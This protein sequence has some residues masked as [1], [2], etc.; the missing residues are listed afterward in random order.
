MAAATLELAGQVTEPA[1]G[2]W[3]EVEEDEVVAL[4]ALEYFAL[5][6]WDPLCLRQATAAE[7][8]RLPGMTASVVRQ[9]VRLVQRRPELSYAELADSLA[10]TPEQL[11]VLQQATTLDCPLPDEHRRVV[12]SAVTVPLVRVQGEEAFV[13][14]LWKL[15]G[16]AFGR[17]GVWRV[18]CV[19]DR[20]AGEPGIADFVSAS[21]QA[22]PWAGARC[23]VGDFRLGVGMG[24]MASSSRGFRRPG[25]ELGAPLRWSTEV[26]P[27]GSVQESSFLRGVALQWEWGTG[28]VVGWFSVAPRSGS[29]DTAGVVRS[30]VDD[31]I[32]ATSRDRSRRYAFRERCY[33]TAAE[34]AWGH[35]RVLLGGMALSYSHPLATQSRRDFAGRSG[36][37]TTAAFSFTP[38][39]GEVGVELVRDARGFWGIHGGCMVARPEFRLTVAVRSMPDGFRSPF[40]SILSR[41]T[42][43]SN[44][45]GLYVG[46]AWDEGRH[47]FW[48]YAD[49]FRTLA[50][51]YGMPI[52]QL[53]SEIG[54]RWKYSKQ[55]SFDWWLHARYQTRLTVLPAESSR[56]LNEEGIVS[57]RAD[58]FGVIVRGWRWHLRCEFRQGRV[59]QQVNGWLGMIG[60]EGT[61]QRWRQ[62]WGLRVRAG[63]YS[64]SHEALGFRY[65]EYAAAGVPRLHFLMGHGSYV[66]GWMRWSPVGW[67]ELQGSLVVVKRNSP[68]PLQLWGAQVQGA[69]LCLWTLSIEIRL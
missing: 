26:R 49:L 45:Q 14:P 25:F 34:V 60:C 68:L 31:G 53:G 58:V 55:K 35:L 19:W 11:W 43:V 64:V 44:E 6:Q 32:F 24:A 33:G 20:D 40:G 29:I 69:A 27:W 67:L 28:V 18:E 3:L 30:V 65:Y 21:L 4:S 42:A 41:S 56:S 23:L 63:V 48:A 59:P 9:L 15:Q 66:S 37:L 10:L 12:R 13:G 16:N 62:Q 39:W 46:I 61:M 54:V 17:W 1:S 5:R 51:P 8:Q 7:L 47:R 57:L 36:V 2:G 52:R 38:D 22:E 50:P